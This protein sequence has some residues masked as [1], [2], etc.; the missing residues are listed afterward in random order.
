MA[1]YDKLNRFTKIIFSHSF[2]Y[3]SLHIE[4]TRPY[5]KHLYKKNDTS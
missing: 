1:S 3:E 4:E 2:I 5:F